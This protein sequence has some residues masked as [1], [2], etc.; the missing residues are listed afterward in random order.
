[1]TRGDQYRANLTRTDEITAALAEH[2][3]AVAA[4]EITLRALPAR[5]ERVA[6]LRASTDQA[7]E[8]AGT[9]QR[10]AAALDAIEQLLA[11][12]EYAQELQQQRDAIQ[13]EIDALGYDSDAHNAARE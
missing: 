12:G 9:I 2:K 6:S 10:E 7:H 4:I 1:T 11:S 8:A 5:R 13:A 3:D